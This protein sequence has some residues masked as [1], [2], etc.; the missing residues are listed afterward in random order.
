M[1]ARR[2]SNVVGFD[3]AP[4]ARDHRGP[5]PLVG[6]VFADRRLDGVLIGAI[7]KDGDDATAVVVDLV[8]RSRFRE[9]VRLVLLQGVAFAGFNVVDPER[10]HRGLGV[11]VLV[12]ARRPP[13][14]AAVRRALLTRVAGGAE[15]WAVVERLGPMEA[16]GGVQV[17]R[18][19]LSLA[20]AAAAVERLAIHGALP[21]PLRV[22]H[23]VAG[24][25]VRGESRGRA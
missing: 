19:G 25:L 2:L 9:H 12:V 7:E 1:R 24:A 15:K 13:N 17:Q 18:A 22:A 23:L 4:F 5:V 21:E 11:P 14:L 16:A 6:A 8:R 10:V 20:E 3:D